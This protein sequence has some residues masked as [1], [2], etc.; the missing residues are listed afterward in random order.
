[1]LSC[2]KVR[3]RLSIGYVTAR[4]KEELS[5][6]T[7]IMLIRISWRPC[8]TI[9]TSDVTLAV[10]AWIKIS[11][12]MIWLFSGLLPKRF[13]NYWTRA[14]SLQRVISLQHNQNGLYWEKSFHLVEFEMQ[15]VPLSFTDDIKYMG[16][17][18]CYSSENDTDFLSGQL[19][20]IHGKYDFFFQK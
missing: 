6:L 2:A 14:M 7:Y 4:V 19:R 20:V 16:H 1:M 11:T 3:S 15:T 18:I 13:R 8:W 17:L 12:R 9:K 10:L 5:L